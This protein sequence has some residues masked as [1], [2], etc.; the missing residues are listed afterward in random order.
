MNWKD[1]SNCKSVYL[2]VTSFLKTQM[3]LSEL[4][5]KACVPALIASLAIIET[6]DHF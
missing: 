5:L 4:K 3:L 6:E 1:A 2:D